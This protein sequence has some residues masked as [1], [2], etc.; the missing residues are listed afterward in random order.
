M[1][2]FLTITVSKYS[3]SEEIKKSNNHGVSISIVYEIV[4]EAVEPFGDDVDIVF[5]VE[6]QSFGI[7]ID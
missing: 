2:C 5:S 7:D 3:N 6:G 1:I 4:D